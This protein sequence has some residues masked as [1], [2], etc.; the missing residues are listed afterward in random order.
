MLATEE[1]A[2]RVQ[3]T[4]S[5]AAEKI[6]D[7]VAQGQGFLSPQKC[8]DP[9]TKYNDKMANQFQRPSFDEAEHRKNDPPPED[10]GPPSEQEKADWTKT[11][12]AEVEKLIVNLV[13]KSLLNKS[14]TFI[15]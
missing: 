2:R 1:L 7:V 4:A 11:K 13:I 6:K 9:D 5:S 3:G 12:P 15:P 14:K 8:M 10:F